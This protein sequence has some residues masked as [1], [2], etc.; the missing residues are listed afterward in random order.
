[1]RMFH[2]LLVGALLITGSGVTS[3]REG[4]WAAT[5]L[6]SMA[7][8]TGRTN[9][10]IDRYS[11]SGFAGEVSYEVDDHNSLGLTSGWQRFDV[12]YRDAFATFPSGAVFGSQVRYLTSIPLLIT[13]TH[14][15]G[16]PID[17]IKPYF[18]IGAGLYW[19]TPVLEVG[20]YSFS[21]TNVHF[22]L[23][24]SVGMDFKLDRK[25]SMI[26]QI[27]YNAALSSGESVLGSSSNAQSY[28]GLKVGF[29][30]AN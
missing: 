29:R 4:D 11:W 18:K 14:V 15:M 19:M 8:P 25:S 22:G 3:A 21:E 1:M 2:A 13:A 5:F 17:H 6:Y 27:D 28:I 30:F 16:D 7:S 26:V 23:M 10:Y 12:F 9:D 24:P 20:M